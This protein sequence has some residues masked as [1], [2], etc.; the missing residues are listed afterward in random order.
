MAPYK[1][2]DL[3]VSNNSQLFNK[4]SQLVTNED[5]WK[6]SSVPLPETDDDDRVHVVN[7]RPDGARFGIDNVRFSTDERCSPR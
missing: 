7:G 5:N 2:R 4:A 3:Q 6:F 1:T